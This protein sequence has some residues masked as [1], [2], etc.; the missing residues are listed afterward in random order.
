MIYLWEVDT[1]TDQS[2]N[3]H[4]TGH[5]SHRQKSTQ[6]LQ[7]R[8]GLN[9]YGWDASEGS[10]PCCCTSD[11]YWLTGAPAWGVV[12]EQVVACLKECVNLHTLGVGNITR[13]CFKTIPSNTRARTTDTDINTDIEHHTGESHVS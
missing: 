3:N 2:L 7:Q 9:V 5:G 11:F 10:C 6:S 13:F 8:L 12:D 1:I 4:F